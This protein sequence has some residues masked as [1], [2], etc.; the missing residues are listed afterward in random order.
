M[1]GKKATR[2]GRPLSRACARTQAGCARLCATARLRVASGARTGR[3]QLA[4]IAHRLVRLI[5]G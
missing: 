3:A 5:G 1:K 4:E 2:K